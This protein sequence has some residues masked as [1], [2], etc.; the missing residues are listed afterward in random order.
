MARKT[1][2]K[3]CQHPPCNLPAHTAGWCNTHYIRSRNGQDMDVPIRPRNR[4]RACQ[5]NGCERPVQ[6]LG[7]CATHYE[8]LRSG[9][10]MAAPI[11]RKTSCKAAWCDRPSHSKGYCGTHYSRF[12]SGL[13]IDAPIV[14]RG[15]SKGEICKENGC[16]RS[17]K[18]L[19]WCNGHYIRHLRGQPMDAPVRDAP[20]PLDEG[21]CSHPGCPRMLSTGAGLCK[22]H[23]ERKRT[24]RDM[25]A[26]VREVRKRR[27][28][29]ERVVRDDGY[30]EVRKPDHFGIGRSGS[31]VWFYEHRYVM[32]TYLGRQLHDGENVHHK[33]GDRADNRLEN[34]ELWSSQQPSGQRVVDLLERAY[35]I[36]ERYKDER[37]KLEKLSNK[38]LPT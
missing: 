20:R 16:D 24:G 4:G 8:R 32:E 34:L 7:Y 5:Q 35:A 18:N 27:D 15:K 10:D 1:N 31:K 13:E 2:T 29:L 26:P 30:V 9:R 23:Y 36:R 22:L 17:V 38:R 19:G 33:N 12:K 3:T 21:P 6:S 14:P 11:R 25:D 37:E 28:G